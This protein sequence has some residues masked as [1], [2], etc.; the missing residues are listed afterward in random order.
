MF[1]CF[2]TSEILTTAFHLPCK[3][4]VERAYFSKAVL[5]LHLPARIYLKG[6]RVT[7]YLFWSFTQVCV[8]SPKPLFCV[9]LAACVFFF[10]LAVNYLLLNKGRF[11]DFLTLVF[12]EVFFLKAHNNF[13]LIQIM[14]EAPAL[15]FWAGQ[16]PGQSLPALGTRG[17]KGGTFGR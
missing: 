4:L 13:V 10:F 11:G 7:I 2:T 16:S 12:Q 3:E 17:A 1:S 15:S 8:L 14:T 6:Y 9:R 5:S